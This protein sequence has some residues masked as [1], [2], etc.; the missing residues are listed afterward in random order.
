MMCEPHTRGEANS[1][2]PAVS[3]SSFVP[4]SAFKAV[5]RTPDKDLW[6]QSCVRQPEPVGLAAKSCPSSL[7]FFDVSLTDEKRRD[8]GSRLGLRRES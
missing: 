1:S 4:Q 2:D 7:R 5:S 6:A 3:R 8:L